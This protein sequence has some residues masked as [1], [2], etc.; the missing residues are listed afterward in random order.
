M[1][2]KYILITDETKHN[3]EAL[4]AIEDLNRKTNTQ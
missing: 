4:C 3:S 2:R 1:K